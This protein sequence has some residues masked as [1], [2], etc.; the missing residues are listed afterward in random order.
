M[1]CAKFKSGAKTGSEGVI[2]TTQLRSCCGRAAVVLG[3][4]VLDVDFKAANCELAGAC[5]VHRR[6]AGRVETLRHFLAGSIGQTWYFA[7]NFM[8]VLFGWLPMASCVVANASQVR[9]HLPDG[10]NFGCHCFTKSTQPV[11]KQKPHSQVKMVHQNR[12]WNS[13]LVKSVA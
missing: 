8:F 10:L 11:I 13:V 9:V 2:K 3:V 1:Q 4:P 5:F 6:S 12:Q 7:A